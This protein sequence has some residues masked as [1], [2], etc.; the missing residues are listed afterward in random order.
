MWVYR[1]DRTLY[2]YIQGIFYKVIYVT[3]TKLLII[4]TNIYRFFFLSILSFKY[5]LKRYLKEREG[6]NYPQTIDARSLH[7]CE[8]FILNGNYKPRR[9]NQSR[10]ESEDRQNN[11][12]RHF[13]FISVASNYAFAETD[14]FH[15]HGSTSLPLI[16]AHCAISCLHSFLFQNSSSAHS[17]DIVNRIRIA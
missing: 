11:H 12:E 10:R 9:C 3:T 5:P 4:C 7:L 16:R 15:I 6:G 8:T 17:F 1:S 13:L 14:A 2:I